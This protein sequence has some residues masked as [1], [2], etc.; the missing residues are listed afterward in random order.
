MLGELGVNLFILISGYFGIKFKLRKFISLVI[1]VLFYFIFIS[2][3]LYGLGVIEKPLNIFDNFIGY[4]W[5]ITD[6][7]VLYLISPFINKLIDIQDKKS[8]KKMLY[9]LLGIFCIVPTILGLNNSG[10]ESI[11]YYNRFS[12]IIIMYIFGTYV[13]KYGLSGYDH[14]YK[15]TANLIISI[16]LIIL[17]ITT[18]TIFGFNIPSYYFWTPNSILMV[19]MS[20]SIFML[21]KNIK[22]KN[23]IVINIVSS[24][25]LGVYLLHDGIARKYLWQFINT[26]EITINL[27][28]RFLEYIRYIIMIFAVCVLIDLIRQVI[29]KFSIDKI[30]KKLLKNKEEDKV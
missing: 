25:S 19:Y 1:E 27:S 28:D 29:F 10:T 5:F 9:I 7:I 21:F 14:I 12:W 17:S 26:K 20:I 2:S 8:N 4:W 30:I 18:I 11:V 23:N 13:R 3:V 24:T 22:I 16:L 15:T 6:Y